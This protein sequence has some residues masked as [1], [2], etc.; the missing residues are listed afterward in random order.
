MKKDEAR[1][2][3]TIDVHYELGR[4]DIR[5]LERLLVSAADNLAANGCFSGDTEATVL[6]WSSSVSKWYDPVIAAKL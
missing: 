2:R 4:T 1:L 6:T 5:E 3:L